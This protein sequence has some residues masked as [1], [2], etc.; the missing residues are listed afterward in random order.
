MADQ[1][2]AQNLFS[3][4]QRAIVARLVADLGKWYN[5]P[6]GVI[7]LAEDQADIETE[8]NQRTAKTGL[9]LMIII[10]KVTRGESNGQRDVTIQ[11]SGFENVIQNR[12]LTGTRVALVDI[13]AACD[14]SL[15]RWEPA[16]AGGDP[17]GFTPLQVEDQIPVALGEQANPI[18][19]RGLTLS[20]STFLAATESE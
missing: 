17:L 15:D 4:L 2:T 18:V 16:P 8:I 5:I 7:V 1:F 12:S 6:E 13:L 10:T 20:T 3:S 9:C 14:G 11:I 19:E